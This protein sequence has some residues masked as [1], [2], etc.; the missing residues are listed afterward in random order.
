MMTPGETGG[1]RNYAGLGEPRRGD[2]KKKYRPPRRT[3]VKFSLTQSRALPGVIVVLPLRG[4]LW[5]LFKF[6]S[7]EILVYP[8]LSVEP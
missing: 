2:T 5:V 8:I 4:L 6:C 1:V 7:K 3:F